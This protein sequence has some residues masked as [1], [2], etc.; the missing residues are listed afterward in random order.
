M[1]RRPQSLA[2][3]SAAL[4]RCAALP[5]CRAVRGTLSAAST[6]RDHLATAR[7][8][9]LRRAAARFGESHAALAPRAPAVDT[10]RV[11]SSCEIPPPAAVSRQPAERCSAALASLVAA[12]RSALAP[13]Q[14]RH[15]CDERGP[16]ARWPFSETSHSPVQRHSAALP[17]Q[18]TVPHPRPKL[19]TV[20]ATS[21]AT[22]LARCR[23][24]RAPHGCQRGAAPSR[25]YQRCSALCAPAPARYAVD[26][27]RRGPATCSPGAA[28]L[29]ALPPLAARLM[30]P[31]LLRPQR[32]G[33]MRLR[34]WLVIAPRP[35]RR[36]S[37][38]RQL[39][40]RL[41]TYPPSLGRVSLRALPRSGAVGVEGAGEGVLE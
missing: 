21:A 35:L 17:S 14:S 34:G 18:H 33:R 31:Q 32:A 25:C 36:R 5:H 30:R 2:A 27:A 19:L 6:I 13:H 4:R 40:R 26:R 20:D 41:P 9:P 1:W 3:A 29:P 39:I 28:P 24:P 15:R 38:R 23:P 12:H 11:V 16:P 37:S 8:A 10:M 22:C 7:S